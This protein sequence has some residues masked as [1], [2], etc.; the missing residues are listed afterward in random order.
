MSCSYLQVIPDF[1]FFPLHMLVFLFRGFWGKG[2]LI[3]AWKRAM[4]DERQILISNQTIWPCWIHLSYF[5]ERW[6]Y[7]LAHLLHFLIQLFIFTIFIIWAN[8]N[9][10]DK[11]YTNVSVS[12]TVRLTELYSSTWGQENGVSEC[13]ESE[14]EQI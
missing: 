1:F 5:L 7:P 13:M 10:R 6:K 11:S 14:Q 8:L 2:Y 3:M 4:K 12:F 9:F